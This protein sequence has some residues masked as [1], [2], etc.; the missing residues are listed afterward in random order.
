MTFPIHIA[1]H[2]LSV[3][4]IHLELVLLGHLTIICKCVPKTHQPHTDKLGSRHWRKNGLLQ[5][6]DV[7]QLSQHFS[8]KLTLCFGAKT[9]SLTSLK[10]LFWYE[11]YEEQEFIKFSVIGISSKLK[12]AQDTNM[13]RIISTS[14]LYAIPLPEHLK[15]LLL[16][17][18]DV[19]TFTSLLHH[20]QG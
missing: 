13:K 15:E 16:E 8:L 6:R 17:Q 18:L 20:L 3:V 4:F 9:F 2:S 14:Y 7:K 19:D 11:V 12:Y 5:V 1:L 10:S